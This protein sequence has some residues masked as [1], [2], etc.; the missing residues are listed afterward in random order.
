MTMKSLD[1]EL[2]KKW[3]GDL[4][5]EIA[6]VESR[7]E[8]LMSRRSELKE[9]LDAV[10]RLIPANGNSTPGK[11]AEVAAKSQPSAPE[12]NTPDKARFT[13]VELYHIPLM[14]SLLE[15]GGSASSDQVIERVGEKM[16]DILTREDL[17]PLPSGV[18]IRWRN[19]VAWQRHNLKR[20]GLIRSDSPRGVW[21]MTQAGRK[22][23]DTVTLGGKCFR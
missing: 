8:P 3:K 13:P 22:W 9:K 10:K 5:E 21:Q 19:R 15:L 12:G 23:L 6:D 16:A 4:E 7:L 17:E 14:Q 2:L 18:D 20:R 11:R 1:E